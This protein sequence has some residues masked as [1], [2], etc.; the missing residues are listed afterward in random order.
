MIIMKSK[1]ICQKYFERNVGGSSM[2]R[3]ESGREVRS[4]EKLTGERRPPKV[5]TL[6]GR[7]PLPE[8]PEI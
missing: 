3:S 6:L 4:Q 2:L 7:G 1:T 5:S 8:G